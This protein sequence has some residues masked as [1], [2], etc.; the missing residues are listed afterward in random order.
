MKALIYK[1]KKKWT[2]SYWS[3]PQRLKNL[4]YL[5][6]RKCICPYAAAPKKLMLKTKGQGY[7]YAL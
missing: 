6:S 1:G 2:L 7:L 5:Q 4:P 3:T